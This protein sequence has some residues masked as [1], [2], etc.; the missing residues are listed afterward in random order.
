MPAQ[1]RIFV[2]IGLLIVIFLGGS[3]GHMVLEEYTFFQGLYMSAI[4]YSFL[5]PSIPCD[6]AAPY[7]CP[8]S[9]KLCKKGYVF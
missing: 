2:P 3:P 7:S 8:F 9:Q 1:N 5:I 4:T 6:D